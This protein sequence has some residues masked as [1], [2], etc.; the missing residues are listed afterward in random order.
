MLLKHFY[1]LHYLLHTAKLQRFIYK[2]DIRQSQTGFHWN[3]ADIEYKLKNLLV[4][5][6]IF[7]ITLTEALFSGGCTFFYFPKIKKR[8]FCSS[9]LRSRMLIFS[10]SKFEPSC[11]TWRKA[12]SHIGCI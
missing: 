5:F 2:N 11:L 9:K 12:F 6:L 4:I 10:K 1:D 7:Q 3:L 8:N